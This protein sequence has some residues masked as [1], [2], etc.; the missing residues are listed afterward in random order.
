MSTYGEYCEVCYHPKEDVDHCK[1][2]RCPTCKMCKG[3]GWNHNVQCKPS[4]AHP[5]GWKS[6]KCDCGVDNGN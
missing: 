5:Y 3:T 6:A 2:P 4:K 1:H